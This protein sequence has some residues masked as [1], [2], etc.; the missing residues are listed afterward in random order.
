MAAPPLET[1]TCQRPGPI[2]V[3]LHRRTRERR[4]RG[5]NDAPRA[6][7]IGHALG[8]S[9]PDMDRPH[10]RTRGRRRQAAR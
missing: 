10:T 1:L 3:A 7:V 6:T 8:L 9:A 5:A 2:L 4:V